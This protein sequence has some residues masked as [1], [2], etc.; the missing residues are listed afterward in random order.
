MATSL[1]CTAKNDDVARNIVEELK[2][3]GVSKKNVSVLFPDR[4]VTAKFAHDKHIELP[5][6]GGVADVLMG[7]GITKIGADRYQNRIRA[8]SIL[9]SV[10]DINNQEANHVKEIFK[11]IGADDIAEFRVIA[12]D[13]L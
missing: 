8:G 1:F 13:S 4:D 10:H 2:V 11:E 3:S 9:I 7:L 12:V 5:K 6:D